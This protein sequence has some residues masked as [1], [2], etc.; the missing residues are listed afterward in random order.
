LIA[1][2]PFNGSARDETGSG[3]H[4]IVQNAVLT[5]DRFGRPDSAYEFKGWK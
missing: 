3:S 1:N 2:Y 4:G 5:F